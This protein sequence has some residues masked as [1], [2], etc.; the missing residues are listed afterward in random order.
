MFREDFAFELQ[1]IA[2]FHKFVRVASV[3]ILAAELTA[4]IGIDHPVKR[5]PGAVAS[6]QE[7]AAGQI[8]ILNPIFRFE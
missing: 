3:A 8:E 6:R 2:Q 1:R 5:D 7:F 4:A